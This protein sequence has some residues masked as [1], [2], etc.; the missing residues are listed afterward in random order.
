[1]REAVAAIAEHYPVVLITKGDLFHQEAK[2]KVA[3]LA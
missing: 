3:N 1:M 2:I